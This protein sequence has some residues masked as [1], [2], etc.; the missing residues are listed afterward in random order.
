MKDD[1]IVLMVG[2]LPHPP[3]THTHTTH[4]SHT[5][6]HTNPGLLA[7]SGVVGSVCFDQGSILP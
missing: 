1:V 4:H 3:P 2:G 5:H 6:T 7:A